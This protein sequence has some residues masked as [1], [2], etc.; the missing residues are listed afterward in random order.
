MNI[1]ISIIIPTCNRKDKLKKCLNSIFIQDYSKDK[2]EI[3]VVDDRQD[4]EVKEVVEALSKQNSFCVKYFSQ[5]CK[6]PAK[7]RNLGVK[8]SVGDIV[9]F[10]DDDCIA[11]KDWIKLMISM[12]RENLEVGVVGGHTYCDNQKISL[13]ASQFLSNCSIETEIE[14]K[15]ELIFFPTCNVSLKRCILNK[16]QFDEDFLFPGGEDLDFFWRLFKSGIKSIWYKDIKVMHCREDNLHSFM[17]QAYL[18]GRGNILVKHRHNGHVLLKELKIGSISFWW[19]T[20]I[21]SI[22]IPRFSYSLGKKFIKESHIEGGLKRIVSYTY[23]SIHKIFYLVGNICE[24]FRIRRNN[25]HKN[26]SYFNV[27]GLIILDITHKCNLKCRICDI[28]KTQ[29]NEVP[30]DIQYIKKVF[31]QAKNLGINEIALSGGE[32]LLREDIF[33]IFS[34]AEK[35]K[36]KNL[37][38]LTNGIIVE[39][40]MDKLI[41][42]LIKNTISLVISLDSVTPD[43]HNLIRNFDNAW[44]K[45]V[46]SLEILSLL[47]KKYPKINVNVIS[48]VLNNNLEEL[49]GLVNFIKSLKVNSLQFQALLPN[50]MQMAKRVKSDFWVNKDRLPVLDSSIDKLIKAK[51]DDR[52]FIKN[53]INNLALMKNYYRGEILSCDVRCSSASKTV[54][55]SSQGKF[56]TCFSD[57]GDI[58]SQDLEDIFCGQKILDAREGIKKCSWPCLLPCFCD[59]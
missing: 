51:Q 42:Y 46:K 6:G 10:I 16:F 1:D 24:F 53:S 52:L 38:V 56:T 50:N 19:S 31:I 47:K 7:A 9:A 22:K 12:H 27:P 18:Y 33:E 3:V 57:Y 36:I 8:N 17:K 54:L 13:L 5:N 26:K 58:K 23:F 34:F 4:D 48:I 11:D 35:L 28:W 49:P 37:G 15:K 25:L 59:V 14:G 55:M 39:S 40:I 45:T 44:Q 30:L 41:P 20:F 21:N 29:E 2:V 32:A 43:V